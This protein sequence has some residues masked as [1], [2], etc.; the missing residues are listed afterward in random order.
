[1]VLQHSKIWESEIIAVS[2]QS[3][4]NPKVPCLYEDPG[5]VESKYLSVEHLEYFDENLHFQFV[6][7]K[8]PL[9]PKY[10]SVSY[11]KIKW[12]ES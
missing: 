6:K 1:V 8:V 2:V 7:R 9:S 3:Y 5:R 10:V 11:R 12:E 4:R